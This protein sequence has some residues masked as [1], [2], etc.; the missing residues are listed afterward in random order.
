M[1]GNLSVRFSEFCGLP[2]KSPH[3]DVDKRDVYL[4]LKA[5]AV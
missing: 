2:L 5:I 4:R 1:P 3:L